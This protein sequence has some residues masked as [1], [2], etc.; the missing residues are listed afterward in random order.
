MAHGASLTSAL[1]GVAHLRLTWRHC[2]F[3]WWCAVDLPFPENSTHPVLRDG[4]NAVALYRG[5]I[6]SFALGKVLPTAG[7]LDAFVYT[8]TEGVS[9]ELLETLTLGRPA[10]ESTR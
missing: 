4:P 9:P 6:S 5:N 1:W 2:S 3:P 8:N 10:L 7:L